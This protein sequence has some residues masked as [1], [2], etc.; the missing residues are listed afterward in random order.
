LLSF[1]EFELFVVQ[2]YEFLNKI[3]SSAFYESYAFF[4]H[5]PDIEQSLTMINNYRKYKKDILKLIRQ[6]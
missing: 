3:S 1:D 5:H 4:N 2:I 6:K